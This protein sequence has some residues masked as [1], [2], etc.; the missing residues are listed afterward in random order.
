MGKRLRHLTRLTNAID[1]AE[2]KLTAVERELETKRAELSKITSG[3]FGRST[4]PKRAQEKPQGIKRYL[5][6]D[7]R[8]VTDG[9]GTRPLAFLQFDSR[10][11]TVGWPP[12]LTVPSFN[13]DAAGQKCPFCGLRFAPVQAHILAELTKPENRQ[14]VSLSPGDP[15]CV[16]LTTDRLKIPLWINY[17]KQSEMKHFTLLNKHSPFTPD[18]STYGCA[19]GFAKA[20]VNLVKCAATCLLGRTTTKTGLT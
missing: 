1:D 5:L 3:D 13:V 10:D 15:T 16:R 19:D 17:P 14:T 4:E 12:G 7:W 18:P 6:L 8:F 9:T 20:V 11:G 2:Q